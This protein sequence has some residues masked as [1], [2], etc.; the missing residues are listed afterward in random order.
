MIKPLGNRDIVEFVPDAD[1]NREHDGEFFVV[2]VE[3]GVAFLI[4]QEKSCFAGPSVPVE[5]L[6]RVRETFGEFTREPFVDEESVI[7]GDSSY[8][9]YE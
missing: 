2:T 9:Y 3:D 4:G 7:G 6:R 5:Q 8:E 1:G